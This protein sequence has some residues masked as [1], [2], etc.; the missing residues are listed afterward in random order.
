MLCEDSLFARLDCLLTAKLEYHLDASPA[1][2]GLSLKLAEVEA[3]ISDL[4]CK[5]G[6]AELKDARQSQHSQVDAENANLI[7]QVLA[8]D[9]KLDV[10]FS[11][12]EATLS[13]LRSALETPAHQPFAASLEAPEDGC[14]IAQKGIL[15][16]EQLD[17][18]KAEQTSYACDDGGDLDF[19]QC[20]TFIQPEDG[21]GAAS[22]ACVAAHAAAVAPSNDDA[23]Y[24]DDDDAATNPFNP[25][26]YLRLVGDPRGRNWDKPRKP[27]KPSRLKK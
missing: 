22:S 9:T 4:G 17:I 16:C 21:S 12:F 10:K 7:G 13:E 23:V 8:L 11:I 3:A 26:E 20:V 27:K 6:T 25:G 15:T 19:P 18:E 14:D 1:V 5:Y 2:T 24:H